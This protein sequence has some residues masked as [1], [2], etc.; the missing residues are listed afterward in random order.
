MYNQAGS[1]GGQIRVIRLGMF[2]NNNEFDNELLITYKARTDM[3]LR[4]RK[5][6]QNWH[7]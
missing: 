2:A 4:D 7:L 1:T 6:K 3:T 5:L